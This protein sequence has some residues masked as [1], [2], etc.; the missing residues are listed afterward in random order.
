MQPHQVELLDIVQAIC[1]FK[2]WEVG[3][4]GFFG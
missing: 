1:E 3:F 2:S 4:Y